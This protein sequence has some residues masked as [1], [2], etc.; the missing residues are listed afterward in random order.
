MV[1]P[2]ELPVPRER[3]A[4]V[5]AHYGVEVL[6][7]IMII[8]TVQIVLIITIKIKDNDDMI[9]VDSSGKKGYDGNDDNESDNDNAGDDDE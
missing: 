8:T 7:A 9:P 1:D 5:D 3:V 6:R 2:V 4:E